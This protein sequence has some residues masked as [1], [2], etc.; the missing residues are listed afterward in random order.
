[1]IKFNKAKFIHYSKKKF[2]SM[3]NKYV[4]VL[5]AIYVIIKDTIR[6]DIPKSLKY[7]FKL[8]DKLDYHVFNAAFFVYFCNF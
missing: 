5:Y 3:S 4:R 1:M 6:Y 8:S 2:D 7:I